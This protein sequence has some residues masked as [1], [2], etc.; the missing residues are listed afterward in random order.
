VAAAE[1]DGAVLTAPV[2]AGWVER[3]N[4]YL[5]GE[6][7]PVAAHHAA[8]VILLRDAPGTSPD[9]YMLKRSSTMAFAAGFYAFPGGR[10]DPRDADAAI[11]WAGP[12]PAEWAERFGA[13]EAEAR[14]MLCAAVRETFEESGVLFAGP[15]ADHVVEDTTGE[16]W[17]AD[18][19]R[20]VSRELSL[21][22]F[23]ERRQLVLRSDLLG[24][25][26]RWVTP[27]FEPRRYDTVFFVAALP[28]GQRTR[29]VSG[30]ADGTVWTPPP[31]AIAD[32]ESG[33]AAMMPPT[34]TT[35]REMSPYQ[36]AQDAL[37]AA[38]AR[39]LKPIVVTVSRHDDGDLYLEWSR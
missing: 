22:E 7:T 23:L 29:D 19:L 36:C 28:V 9:V 5:T 4:G 26:S 35:L 11:A 37:T 10:V 2:P 13:D 17:E 20:L 1:R 30:E 25:W 24:G 34:I 12:T 31:A 16:E 21:A 8:T 32:H 18:R 27:E 14:G 38:S 39:D 33:A 6:I 3:I 15:D